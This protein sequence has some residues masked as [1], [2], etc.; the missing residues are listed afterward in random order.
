VKI[1]ELSAFGAG[2]LAGLA[3]GLFDETTIGARLSEA[4]DVIAPQLDESARTAKAHVW[5]A[6]VLSVINS[7]TAR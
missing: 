1:L 3:S 2:T 5:A 4:V 6:A 7:T